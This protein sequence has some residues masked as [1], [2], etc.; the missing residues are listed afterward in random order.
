VKSLS[1]SFISAIAKGSAFSFVISWL[2]LSPL[3]A[4][5]GGAFGAYALQKSFSKLSK[6]K[7][8]QSNKTIF[9]LACAL[10][11]GLICAYVF[12]L[13]FFILFAKTP[14]DDWQKFDFIY[15]LTHESRDFKLY[16]FLSSFVIGYLSSFLGS[17]IA[18]K[19]DIGLKKISEE[20]F[21]SRLSNKEL[22]EYAD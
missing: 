14:S 5:L 10:P 19:L 20:E 15:K 8:L 22:V 17:F 4:C 9:S 21:L 3:F 1:K 2:P 6:E 16:F 7:L 12:T 11:V 18:F 13:L